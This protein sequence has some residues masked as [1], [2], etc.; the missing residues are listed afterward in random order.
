MSTP[1]TI[2]F[3][4]LGD[5]PVILAFIKAAAAEQAPDATVEATEGSLASTLYLSDVTTTNPSR[6]AYTLLITPNDS[7][8]P[9]GLAIYLYTYS[10]WM[11]R[12]GVCLEELYILPEYRRKGY[13]K[14]LIQAMAKEAHESG[15]AKMEW[16]CLE[17]NKKALKFYESLGAK[18]MDDWVV[19][20]VG[21]EGIIG[22][23]ERAS[24]ERI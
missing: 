11:A 13:A 20:K 4:R 23:A 16:V 1:A 18:R 21:K 14:L 7:N 5:I 3:A 24:E 15:C 19:L 6:F 2:H 8:T 10:T 22:L 17:G 12:P 9:V